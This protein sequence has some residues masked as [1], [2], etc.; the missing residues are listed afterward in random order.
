MSTRPKLLF[1][2][3]ETTAEHGKQSPSISVASPPPVP[4]AVTS[5]KAIGERLKPN[6]TTTQ[7]VAPQQTQHASL[8]ADAAVSSA[9]T[10]DNKSSESS[11]PSVSS[12]PVTSSPSV[13]VDAPLH[14]SLPIF[15]DGLSLA[16]QRRINARKNWAKFGECADLPPRSQATFDPFSGA[17]THLSQTATHTNSLDDKRLLANPLLRWTIVDANEFD[18]I[19]KAQPMYRAAD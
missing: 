12:L 15:D 4:S 10:H 7:T 19:L 13:R 14:I 9:L 3:V 2:R 17:I 18:L 5:W 8:V 6:A 11:L 1:K 16:A